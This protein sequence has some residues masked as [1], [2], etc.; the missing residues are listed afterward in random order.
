MSEKKP[1]HKLRLGAL[2]ATIWRNQSDKGDFYSVTPSRAYKQGD[3]WK[4]SD[5]FPYDDLLA[6]SKLLDQAHSW[7]AQQ[8]AEQKA[9]KRSEQAA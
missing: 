3:E 5:S 9:Q 4:E 2:T 8:I 7:I 1:A 6:I